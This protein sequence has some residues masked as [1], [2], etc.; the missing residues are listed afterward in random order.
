MQNPLITVVILNYRRWEALKNTV[1]AVISQSY[2][3]RE[4]IV[5]DNASG[6]ETPALLQEHFPEVIL[7]Q[8]EGNAG[9]AGRNRGVEAAH[10]EWVV[11][12][13]ND[14]FFDS[15]FE[16]QKIVNEFNTCPRAS[17]LV[18]K[19]LEAEGGGLHVRDW[20]HPRS[21]K[22]YSET[23]FE[24]NYIPEG[25]CAFRRWDF[26]D[27]GGYYEPLWIG[28]EGGDLAL[29]L[30]DRGY[31]IYYRPSIRVRHLMSQS[32]RSSW[33]PYYFYT[34][35][36]LWLAIRNYPIGRALPFLAEKLAMMAYFAW[37]TG[38]L[39][40]LMRGIRDAALGFRKVWSTR[41]PLSRT[42][43]QVLASLSRHRPGLWARLQRHREGPQI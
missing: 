22:E 36:Y 37:R 30:L 33:R 18:F 24:T 2:A 35:N 38:N 9:C 43:F 23:E 14:V 40:A 25:A 27:V 20:C 29:R 8:L 41:H 4:I 34:R 28:H 10:G 3:P 21:Y 13:D 26:L 1:S 19:V 5:V 6:D 32:T 11:T 7:L 15:D 31:Q 17:C 42:T 16:L 39:R 12:I